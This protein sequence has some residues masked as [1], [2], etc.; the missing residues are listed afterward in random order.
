[1]P[2]ALSELCRDNLPFLQGTL[3]TQVSL[4]ADLPSSGPVIRGN[5]NQLQQVLL[6]LVTNAW[7]AMGERGGEIRLALRTCPA[8]AIPAVHRVPVSWDPQPGT[9]ACLEIADS[10]PGIADGDLEKL[11]DPFFS[12]RFTGRGMGLSVVL[13]FVQAHGG[14]IS[15][16]SQLGHGCIFRVYVPV[17]SEVALHPVD[18]AASGLGSNAGGTILLVDDDLPLLETAADLLEV[19]GF[20]V[21]SAKDGIEALEVFRAHQN[22]IRCV[23]TDLTMPRLDGWGTLSALREL[24]PTL[25]VI[26]TSGYDRVQVMAGEHAE[27]PQAFLGKPFSL[28]QLQEAVDIAIGS[29]R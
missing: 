23:I 7:E 25:P 19:I 9:Y 26:L 15:V 24:D 5:A 29:A 18:S 20:S 3:P 2:L 13:G 22:E 6:N 1:V 4:M 28:K 8:S 17:S 12:T 11:F 27:H 21:L 10:G 16:E 14:G